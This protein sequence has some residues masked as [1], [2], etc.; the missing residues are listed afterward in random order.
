MSKCGLYVIGVEGAMAMFDVRDETSDGA[1]HRIKFEFDDI[2]G[3]EV[4]R[5]VCR[6]HPLR[7]RTT[8]GTASGAQTLRGKLPVGVRPKAGDDFRTR[9]AR[10]R[11]RCQSTC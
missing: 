9:R 11:R 10:S 4:S 5:H 1:A 8:N 6:T 7:K 3:N 2:V